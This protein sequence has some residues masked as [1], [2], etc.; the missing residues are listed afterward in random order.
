[1]ITDWFRPSRL[2]LVEEERQCLEKVE[3]LE[4]IRRQETSWKERGDNR[5]LSWARSVVEQLVVDAIND[6]QELGFQRIEMTVSIVSNV[7]LIL[8]S[9]RRTLV[10][11]TEYS[12][13]GTELYPLCH[14]LIWW[15]HTVIA[16]LYG[17]CGGQRCASHGGH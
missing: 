14:Q 10:L 1:M 17:Q 5:R 15:N 7:L 2:L 4:K 11:G 9:H 13:T 6:S 16:D 8:K 12:G 3:R